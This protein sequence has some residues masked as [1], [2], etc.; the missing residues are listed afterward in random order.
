[1]LSPRHGFSPQLSFGIVYTRGANP[2]LRGKL[3]RSLTLWKDR[4]AAS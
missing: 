1:M 2:G 4:L 3:T